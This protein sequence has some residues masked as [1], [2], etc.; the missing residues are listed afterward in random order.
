MLIDSHAHIYDEQYGEGGAD[1]IISAMEGDGLEYIVCVGCD[2]PSSA[3]CVD[4]ANANPR[5]YATVGV[6]PYDADTVT[7]DNI[8][9]LYDMAMGCDK[10]VAVGEIG[11][12]YH[13]PDADKKLQL[14]AMQKQYDLARELKL[15]IVF[16]QRD[17]YG[18]FVEFSKTRDYPDGAILHCFSGSKELAEQFVKKNFYISFSGTVTYN[19]AVNIARAAEAVPLDRLLVETDSPYL[20]PNPKRHGLNYPKNVALIAK[21]IAE[22]KGVPYDQIVKITTE[23]A[24]RIFGIK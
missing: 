20:T 6:H 7:E 9:K 13:Y 2:M 1:K 16:H 22:I 21:R 18:D 14:A 23:N 11:L 10:V 17:S 4:I 15:P 5:I 12:D 8:Q 3:V 24:K 19:N